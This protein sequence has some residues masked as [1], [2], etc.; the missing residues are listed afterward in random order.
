MN[1]AFTIILA[2]SL[3]LSLTTTSF[4]EQKKIRRLGDLS[5][6]SGDNRP[7]GSITN[8]TLEKK[9]GPGSSSGDEAQSTAPGSN[10]EGACKVID[11]SSYDETSQR[12]TPGFITTNQVR[13]GD[14]SFGSGLVTGGQTITHKTATY[15]SVTVQNNSNRDKRISV[16][17]IRAHSIKG[18]VSTPIN[19][20]LEYIGAGQT[21]TITGIKFKPISQIV[22]INVACY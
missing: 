13:S 18:N 2:S 1:I 7:L 19:D 11:Y 22:G 12:T 5:S 10:T 21:V 3:V 20:K 9:Y 17:D 15:V 16:R 4:A 6:E 14:T 8:E